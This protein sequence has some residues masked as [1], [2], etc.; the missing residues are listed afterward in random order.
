MLN[1]YQSNRTERLVDALAQNL[2]RNPSGPFE[3]TVILTHSFGL[4]QWLRIAVSERLGIAAGITTSL[5][6]TWIWQLCQ[7]EPGLDP[8]RS[9]SSFD[10]EVMTFVLTRLLDSS[11]APGDHVLVHR[12]LGTG[13]ERGLRAYQL[14]ARLAALFDQYLLYRP[15]WML[16]WERGKNHPEGELA[17]VAELWAELARDVA[18][19]HRVRLY[20]ELESR[21]AAGLPASAPARLSLFGLS[22]LPPAQLRVFEV[23]ARHI[24]VDV[25]FL[26]PC[27]HY[28]GDV[29]SERDQARRSIRELVRHG[30][31]LSDED[32]Y[33]VGNPVLSSMGKQGREFLE[34]LLDL[35][36][37]QLHE[38]WDDPGKDSALALLQRDILLLERGGAF[39]EDPGRHPISPDD[40]SVQI[41]ACHSPLREVEVLYDQLQLLFDTQPDLRPHEVIV[42]MP[43]VST[44][45]PF[46]EARF[47][48]HLP[49]SIA[50]RVGPTDSAL[51][52]SFRTL[53]DSA[54]SRL[55]APEVMDLLEVPLIAARYGLIE[56]DL[57]TVSAWIGQS[58]IRW[59]LSGAE[60]ARRWELPSESHNTWAFGLD[61]MLHGFAARAEDG[62]IDGVLPFDMDGSDVRVLTA[63]HAF[64]DD[65]TVWSE[66]LRE[67]RSVPEWAVTL[68]AL[69]DTFYGDP[70]EELLDLQL[71]R[72]GLTELVSVAAQAGFDAELDPAPMREALEGL[73]GNPGRGGALLSGGITFASLVPMRSIPFRVV[74]LLGMNDGEFP[75]HEPAYSFDVRAGEHRAGDRS[76][77]L[78]DQ[79]LFLEA[80]LSA[81]DVLYLSYRGRR[82]TD[83][84]AML[85]SILVS[86]LREYCE[87]TLQTPAGP[88]DLLTE[89]PLQPFD[90]RYFASNPR[91]ASYQQEWQRQTKAE[92]GTFLTN[93]PAG[94]TQTV[95]ELGDLVSFFRHPARYFLRTRLGVVFEDHANYLDDVEAFTLSPLDQYSLA[96]SALANSLAGVDPAEWREQRVASGDVLPGTPGK[97]MLDEAWRKGAEIVSRVD[98]LIE[99]EPFAKPI[100]LMLGDVRLVGHVGNM[101][102]TGRVFFRTGQ[103]RDRQL[104]ATWV[105]HLA[106][107]AETPGHVTYLVDNVSKQSL[108]RVAKDQ[109]RTLL[110]ALLELFRASDARPP[111]FIPET[112]RTYY[113]SIDKG[114]DRAV[115]RAYERFS[116]GNPGSEGT[117]ESYARLYNLPQDLDDE[118][119]ATAALVY[120]PLFEALS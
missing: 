98:L 34:M 65:L 46:V 68:T 12:Y 87:S 57:A 50:D 37:A 6:A 99:G 85:P 94:P 8:K 48:D 30:R 59:G 93:L 5:P 27:Q 4:G 44:Y 61:R 119:G 49:F 80:V 56:D 71:I 54:N 89:H 116:R 104:V 33:E 39:L 29:S 115:Q 1:V 74:C 102:D 20:T 52:I 3:P 31:P 109:A 2:T 62:L 120:K 96:E 10:T 76:R 13:S 18:E 103:V 53:L 38:H 75:R 55:T 81:R 70:D 63:L 84:R 91:L 66:R 28:W 64:V 77:R 40:Q 67:P 72:D 69:I 114:I 22:T 42:M 17:W 32:Y 97:L 45:A 88:P 78:D 16:D 73:L 82:I 106:L 15:D 112:S 83:N 90:A 118:F 43:S 36:D 79:Y 113:E 21:L 86:E 108:G 14:A 41:H 111:R 100:D 92:N 7:D 107:N 9:R 25:Y 19:P 105:E 110:A 51:L 24:E 117:D 47:R 58:G 26:N 95:I 11:A 35:P 60:K 101:F 23:L